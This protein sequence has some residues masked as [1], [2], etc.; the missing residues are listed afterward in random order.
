MYKRTIVD[1]IEIL[2]DGHVMVRFLK[3]IIDDDGSL[4]SSAYHRASIHP[5]ASID[6]V[7]QDVNSSL[8]EMKMAPVDEAELDMLRAVQPVVQ[9]EEKVQAFREVLLAG[10]PERTVN[11]K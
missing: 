3:Q 6:E 9:T 1:Q 10:P 7:M 5:G 8:I 2:R 11:E 4:L